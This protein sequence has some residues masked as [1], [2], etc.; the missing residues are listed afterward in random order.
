M[1]P[2]IDVSHHNGIINWEALKPCIDSAILRIGYRGYGSKGAI[3]KDKQFERNEAECYRLMIPREYYYFPT[4]ITFSECAE[5]AIWLC[6]NLL[7]YKDLPITIWLDSEKAAPDGSGRSDNLSKEKRTQMLMEL[8]DILR[9]LM[10]AWII[11]I[12]AS[13]SWIKDHLDYTV[14]RENEVALWVARYNGRSKDPDYPYTYWQYKNNGAFPGNG[15]A[16]DCSV[17]NGFTID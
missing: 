14:L 17:R 5:S 13:N 3:V 9:T 6:Y 2:I 12:Y 10:P 1:K 11:G 16:F 15:C 4:D 7:I 8:R